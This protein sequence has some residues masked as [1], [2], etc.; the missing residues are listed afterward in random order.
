MK[1]TIKS[2]ERISW[3]F[4]HGSKYS[5]AGFLSLYAILDEKGQRETGGRTG[6][7]AFV[8]G[9]KLGSAPLRNRAKRR[10]REAAYQAGAPWKGYDVVFVARQ[11]ILKTDFSTTLGTV[12]RLGG[13]LEQGGQEADTLIYESQAKGEGDGHSLPLALSADETHKAGAEDGLLEGQ[14]L[15][16]EAP[17]GAPED[18]GAGS[19]G[20]GRRRTILSVLVGIPRHLAIVCIKV[21]RH[22]ISPLL[23]P[24]CRYIPTCSEYAMVAFDRFGFLK[25]LW[26]SVKRV[27]RCHP[28]CPGGY[29]PVPEK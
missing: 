28:F 1:N 7:V 2:K 18:A 14:T 24:S 26:L 25:G 9:K 12:R 29:D 16:Q 21:Y 4:A 17:F 8:A 10:L 27:G 23:P 13:L 11:G 22:V 6:R 20:K 19:N 3:M 15:H 5:G